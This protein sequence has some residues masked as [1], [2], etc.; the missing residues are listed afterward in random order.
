MP[1][2]PDAPKEPISIS[3]LIQKQQNILAKNGQNQLKRNHLNEITRKAEDLKH[4][5]DKLNK[6]LEETLIDLE[7]AQKSAADLQDESTAEIENSIAN[8]EAINIKVRANFDREKAYIDAEDYRK[9]YT[10]LTAELNDTRQKKANL[11]N[12]AELP[13]TGLSVQDGEL[14]YNGYKW[15]N[16]SSSEQLKVSTAIVR[17]SVMMGKQRAVLKRLKSR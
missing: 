6:Q 13:L 3:D 15:D 8:I 10:D 11:L 17:K 4:Q 7:Q 14:T 1:E 2:Y 9:Q 16:M 12:G 5:I